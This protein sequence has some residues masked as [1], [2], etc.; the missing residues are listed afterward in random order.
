MTVLN[1]LLDA[2]ILLHTIHFLSTI[3]TIDVFKMYSQSSMRYLSECYLIRSSKVH[4]QCAPRDLARL[5]NNIAAGRCSMDSS[6]L[7]V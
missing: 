4:L 3:L 2:S 6:V 5:G 7:Q 1:L